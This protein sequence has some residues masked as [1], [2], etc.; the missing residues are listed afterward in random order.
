MERLFAG[1][2]TLSAYCDAVRSQIRQRI[3]ALTDETILGRA[4]DDLVEELVEAFTV[5][6]PTLGEPH[7]A[8]SQ[9]KLMAG[10]PIGYG[11]MVMRD[12]SGSPVMAQE[13]VLVIPY[14]GDER[15]F[16]LRPHTFGGVQDPVAEFTPGQLRIIWHGNAEQHV[17]QKFFDDHH[18]SI[19]TYLNRITPGLAELN[20]Q[21]PALVAGLIAA[22]RAQI[23]ADREIVAGLSYPI[24]RREDAASIVP[25]A[26]KKVR[27]TRTAPAVSGFT[28]E[29]V[30]DA[31][32]F[33]EA[34]EVLRSAR[35]VFERNPT[36]TGRLGETDLRNILL[37]LLN[38]TFEF[39]G[40]VG[41]EVFNSSGRTD[42]LIRADTRNVLIGECKFYD[43][44]KSVHDTLDQLLRY[45]AWRDTKAV[46][47]MFFRHADFTKAVAD[48]AEA[49]ATH[50]NHTRTVSRI[51][52]ARYDFDFHAQDDQQREIQLVFLPYVIKQARSAS[53][54]T[55]A[56][57]SGVAA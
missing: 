9:R 15:V 25:V 27:P 6:I 26:R 2:T 49:V 33:E 1:G 39:E 40:M 19:T 14:N 57:G 18:A 22:R 4:D 51:D 24:K 21:I 28:P 41:G 52:G 46:L 37:I 43:G 35:D 20:S 54:N 11:G 29:P 47:V 17:I 16:T 12:Y 48:A 55:N 32:R 7:I 3:D 5:D 23:M 42:L 38:N 31:A 56:P 8:S 50:P 44:P 34:L 53:S 45:H 13:V 36:T 10:R 30:L